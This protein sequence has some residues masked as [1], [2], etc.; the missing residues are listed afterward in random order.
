MLDTI[1]GTKLN[2]R[3]DWEKER[4]EK[5]Y[6]GEKF[7]QEPVCT[8]EYVI[9]YFSLGK[10]GYAYF[11]RKADKTVYLASWH[12]EYKGFRDVYVASD[13]IYPLTQFKRPDGS[14][15][16]ELSLHMF[17][18]N[19]PDGQKFWANKL[20]NDF[21]RAQ[22]FSMG[23]QKWSFS[24]DFVE[25]CLISLFCKVDGQ[26]RHLVEENGVYHWDQS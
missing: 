11:Y 25:R 5:L 26:K 15:S 22:F 3:L 12:K 24:D 14:V 9:K 7:S 4:G 21:R 20:Y 8:W 2:V 19:Y 16:L 6:L 1:F 13:I 10:Y 17:A 18:K 23:F